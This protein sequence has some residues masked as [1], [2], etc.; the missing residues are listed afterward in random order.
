MKPKTCIVTVIASPADNPSPRIQ[1]PF[2]IFLFQI[3]NF[4]FQIVLCLLSSAFCFAGT[5]SGGTGTAEDPYQISTVADWQE[6]ITASADWDKHFI[7]LNDIDFGGI[8]LT[9]VAPDLIPWNRNSD[10]TG[11]FDGLPFTGLFDGQG[12]MLANGVI[13]QGEKDY[14]G[15][16]GYLGSGCQIR[17]LSVVHITISGW[18]YVG[19]LCAC[20]GRVGNNSQGG[21]INNCYVS[22]SIRGYRYVG[23]ICGSNEGAIIQSYATGPVGE[24][25]YPDALWG[26]RIGGLCGLNAGSIDR[27]CAIGPVWGYEHTGGLCGL[28]EGSIRQS[29]ASGDVEG[30]LGAG[31]LCGNNRGDY[32]EDCY[33][34]GSVR[35][36]VIG[37]GGLCGGNYGTILTC[38]S[39]GSVEQGEAS[40]GLCGW[41]Y[42]GVI[43]G[44]LWDTETSGW[45]TSYGGTGKTT[46]EM[47]TLSTFTDAGWDFS[48]SDGDPAVWRMLPNAYPRLVWQEGYS[49][50][51]G[52]AEDPFQIA[53]VADF[54]AAG[55][56]PSDW[57]KRFILIADLDFQ[58]CTVLQIGKGETPFS[59]DFE[60]GGHQMVNLTQTPFD[61]VDVSGRIRNLHIRNASIQEWEWAASGLVRYNFGTITGCTLEDSVI[62]GN[63]IGGLVVW[64]YGFLTNCSFHN[65]VVQGI[66]YQTTE[67]NVIGGL[68]AWNYG[69]LHDCS[70]M[71]PHQEGWGYKGM[72][73]GLVGMNYGSMRHCTIISGGWRSF[74]YAIGGLVAR[75]YGTLMNCSV[76]CAMDPYNPAPIGGC[77]GFVGGLAA[78]N[79]GSILRCY[80]EGR[81][82]VEGLGAGLVVNN[83]GLIRDC[84]ARGVI[85]VETEL[86]GLVVANIGQVVH[87]YA[88]CVIH[89]MGWSAGLILRNHGYLENVEV[90]SSFWNTELGFLFPIGDTVG[91]G[92]TTAEMKTRS[93]F[94]SAGWD[95]VGE[96]ANG[97][98]DIW[99]MCA[100]G[101]DYPRLSWEFSDDGDFTCPNGVALDDL[102]YL[103]ARWLATTPETAGAA[104]INSDGQVNLTDLAVVSR[105]WLKE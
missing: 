82:A 14:V 33:A 39:T 21:V 67:D 24:T 57:D 6:L 20:N 31:G 66:D 27:C 96:S 97:M 86:A 34:T 93:T 1:S 95:F 15:L 17:N 26:T 3:S 65:A 63:R 89:D 22:S 55:L 101:V 74:G 91:E 37:A 28:N 19:G 78:E 79:Y 80:F 41:N 84:Y 61:R 87:C 25:G 60:G 4:K 43:I 32:I 10:D 56:R 105:H 71:I 5:Y 47:K 2:S 59:G 51:S 52:T 104:D 94:T 92:K 102:L 44:C 69:T 53:T 30:V 11:I 58:N 75:N 77:G 40:G 85:S 16:F 83:F 12:H 99:R 38:Y 70:G 42:S 90:I 62:T 13:N 18:Y 88:A 50:G 81:L 76:Q 48:F 45:N 49:G 64:N 8:D 98:A 73:G 46:A 54:Y 103:A 36:R 68:V 9:P 7:L 100:D 35:G 23:G 29:F 72:Y